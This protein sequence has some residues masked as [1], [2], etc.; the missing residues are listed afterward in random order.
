MQGAHPALRILQ[1]LSST[2][3]QEISLTSESLKFVTSGPQKLMQMNP[4]THNL[5]INKQFNIILS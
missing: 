1:L 4:L 5:F 3:Q 2:D